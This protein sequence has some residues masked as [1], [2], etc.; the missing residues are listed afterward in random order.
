LLTKH[1]ISRQRLEDLV[2]L[3]GCRYL[4]GRAESAPQV[5]KGESNRLTMADAGGDL[6]GTAEDQE[7]AEP[8]TSALMPHTAVDQDTLDRLYPP[9]EAPEDEALEDLHSDAGD[10]L[11]Q[12][13]LKIA[14][15]I[16]RQTAAQG[17]RR[18]PQQSE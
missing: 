10:A 6:V 15:E 5:K 8:E 12:H 17:R 1:S 3:Y 16:Q 4:G 18:R 14:G 11:F 13:G 2:S 9:L 7:E